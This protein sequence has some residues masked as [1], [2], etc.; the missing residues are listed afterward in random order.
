MVLGASPSC[1]AARSTGASSSVGTPAL[2]TQ[3]GFLARELA[4]IVPVKSGQR[5][6]S[7]LD[8]LPGELSVPI[9]IESLQQVR[10]AGR[11]TT[12]LAAL[13]SIR[14]L[15]LARPR[16]ALTLAPPSPGRLRTQFFFTDGSVIIFIELLQGSHGPSDFG[17]GDFA[18]PVTVERRSHRIRGRRRALGQEGK[19]KPRKGQEEECFCL[20]GFI[21]FGE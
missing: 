21:G 6:A 1:R 2:R 12:L 9:G 20:H 13:A 8:L 5:L 18:V 15:A 16:P 3:A 7:G 17:A 4:V 19:G 10:A 14:T 11:R